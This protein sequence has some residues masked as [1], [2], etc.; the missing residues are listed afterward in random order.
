MRSSIGT[1]TKA[2]IA[3]ALDV[4]QD[5]RSGSS[6]L[7]MLHQ[8]ARDRLMMANQLLGVGDSLLRSSSR[9][10]TDSF[11]RSAVSRYYYGMFQGARGIV[12]ISNLGDD[13]EAHNLLPN[14]LPSDLSNRSV[15]F[16]E[17]KNARALRN[18]AD[19][20]PYP[21]PGGWHAEARALR[22]VAQSFVAECGD[23][24]KSKGI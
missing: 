2:R 1:A 15:R 11:G 9:A 4:E 3:F 8:V 18:D 19:Y 16:N 17:L 22:A 20:D 14:N 6:L 12:F 24:L 7:D 5:I 10:S 13:K 23:Y 21:P